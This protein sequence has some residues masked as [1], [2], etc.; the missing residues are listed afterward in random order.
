MSN[1]VTIRQRGQLTIPDEI[2]Q[3]LVWLET[4]S[5]VNL[6]AEHQEVKIR[7]YSDQPE[8]QLNWQKIWDNIHLARSFQG[9][10]GNLARFILNDRRHH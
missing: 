1:T 6:V 9:K 3:Q 10:H 7:P 4:G 8:P 2:R 5:V